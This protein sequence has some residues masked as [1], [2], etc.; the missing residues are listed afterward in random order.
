M[1]LEAKNVA[2]GLRAGFPDQVGTDDVEVR[3]QVPLGLPLNKTNF[4]KLNKM[5]FLH[6]RFLSM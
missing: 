1:H 6:T 4:S 5:F 2:I 3:E